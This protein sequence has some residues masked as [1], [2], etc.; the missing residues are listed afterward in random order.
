MNQKYSSSLDR[1][2]AQVCVTCPVC[3]RA[4]A[5][6]EGLANKFVRNIEAGLCPFCRAYERVYGKKA[7]DPR[8]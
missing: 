6:Q 1:M 8:P 2:L 4:R 7:H 5:N 3:R